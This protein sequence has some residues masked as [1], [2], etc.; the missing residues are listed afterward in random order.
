MTVGEAFEELVRI[1]HRL[2]SP[3]GCPWDGEQT[4]DSIKP[5]LIEEAYEVVEAI[6]A[7]DDRELRGE[8]GDLLLQIVFHA[9]MAAEQQRFT[10]ADVIAAISS[11]M[12]R[13]HPHVFGD[14]AVSGADEVVR[15]WSRIKADERRT[16]ADASALAGVPRAM[17]A[18]L[19]AQRLSEKAAH[20]GFDW[21]DARGVLDKLR[22]ELDE[23]TAATDSGDRAAAEAELGDLLYA[24][25]SLARHLRLSAEDAL[26]RAADRFS[27]RFRHMEE[28][29]AKQARDIRSARPEE[30]DALWEDAKRHDP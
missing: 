14:T 3:G 28:A 17:P 24:A 13:R 10:I 9:E 25:T 21:T 11:K 12:V 1:M 7:R 2:R 4:H 6:D 20:A 5:Y 26:T 16:A 29:L 23:L 15:N 27:R 22:E 30:L 18:L 19:R 8:L